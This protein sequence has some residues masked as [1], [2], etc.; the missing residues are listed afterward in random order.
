MR[1]LIC[2]AAYLILFTLSQ[3]VFAQ[4]VENYGA[5]I[6][7]TVYVSFSNGSA[8]FRPS[9]N[10]TVTLASA[11]DAAL[12]SIRGRTSTNMPSAKDENLAL[13]RAISARTYLIAQGVSPL[14]ITL[15]YASAA[16]FIADNSTPA[17][18]LQNQ[19]V[20]IDVIYVPAF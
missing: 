19:R 1:P 11:K 17:S 13:A 18:R 2:S 12:V 16:D 20:E 7:T 9:S 5:P 14:K 4:P 8:S 10:D 3:T 6:S 15:N